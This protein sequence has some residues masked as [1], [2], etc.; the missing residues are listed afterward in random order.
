M[1]LHWSPNSPYVRK[2]LIA[3]I[4]TGLLARIECVRSV[5]AM[6]AVNDAVQADNPLGKIPT[7][8]TS[9]GQALYDSLVICEYFS[10]LSPGNTLIPADPDARLVA[11]RWHA[12]GQGLTDLL[13]LWNNER[14][15]PEHLRS[16]P[17]LEAFSTKVHAALDRL[18]SD[19]GQLPLH[20]FNLGHLGIGIALGYLDFRYADLPWRQG[21]PILESWAAT[22]LARPSFVH[23][24]P[25]AQAQPNWQAAAQQ[26]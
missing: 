23:T 19:L 15:R 1:K 26:K 2:V 6:S 16:T 3:A 17:H 22:I 5:V 7:L 9:D 20:D 18:E 8:V 14:N 4:E 13:I 25:E 21:R 11:L 24:S 10:Q 12:L